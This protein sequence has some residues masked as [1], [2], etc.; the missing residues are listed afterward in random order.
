[1]ISLGNVPTE[2]ITLG[3]VPVDKVML[4]DT[5]LW[6]VGLPECDDGLVT[7]GCFDADSDWD[8]GTNWDISGGTLNSAG[9]NTDANSSQVIPLPAGEYIWSFDIVSIS[10]D[11]GLNIYDAA[12][13]FDYLGSFGDGS[14]GTQEIRV[15]RK[16]GQ[17]HVELMFYS[18]TFTGSID[19]V[20]LVAFSG[21]LVQNGSFDEGSDNQ[22]YWNFGAV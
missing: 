16:V 15:T 18:N 14:L 9:D 4:G 12:G 7:N 17:D 3:T 5:Q 1:M 6:P 21:E 20:K 11:D 8:L 19:N 2:V 10:E 22:Y 13:G